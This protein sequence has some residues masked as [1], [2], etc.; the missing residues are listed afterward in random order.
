MSVFFHLSAKGC[1]LLSNKDPILWIFQSLMEM[2]PLFLPSLGVSESDFFP[3]TCL[4]C[5]DDLLKNV[6]FQF[7]DLSLSLSIFFLTVL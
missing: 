6:S 1:S 4:L 5:S 7:N 2:H 3:E